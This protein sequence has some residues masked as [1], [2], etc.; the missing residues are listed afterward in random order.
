M[1]RAAREE[2]PSRR[3]EVGSGQGIRR[4]LGPGRGAWMN[5]ERRCLVIDEQPAIRLGVRGLLVGPLRGRGGRERRGGARAA[6]LRRLRRRDRRAGAAANGR[7]TLTG[8]P[9][10]RALRKAQPAARDRRPRRPPE[11]HAASEAIDAGA[12]AYV[13][14]S[15]PAD[16]ARPRGR[17]GRRG[18]D[19]RRPG[20]AQQ[21]GTAARHLTRRQR[22]ILQLYAN[23]HSTETPPAAS[24]SAPR[25][26]APT[27][28]PSCRASRPATAPTRSRSASAASLIERSD[29]RHCPDCAEPRVRA[30][31]RARRAGRLL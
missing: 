31:G 3:L 26:S 9:A 8:M 27:P 11:R 13:A 12:T 7:D 25:P 17:R 6:Q 2:P 28:R 10:I 23:G 16:R 24:A 19:L 4:V 20:G 1:D 22:Q 30:S 15:S 18:R 21:A 5:D 29:P 14:K